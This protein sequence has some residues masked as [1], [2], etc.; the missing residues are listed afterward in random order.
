MR[1]MYK[2]T[3]TRFAILA[4]SAVNEGRAFGVETVQTIGLLV[5]EGVVLGH[6]LPSNLGRNDF[7]V[8][9]GGG[10]TVRHAGN[11]C[12][13]SRKPLRKSFLPVS[14]RSPRV[15]QYAPVWGNKWT[16]GVWSLEI[17][18]ILGRG[19]GGRVQKSK[20][21]TVVGVEGQKTR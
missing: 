14:F 9:C 3:V 8:N 16:C 2:L 4:F 20:Q 19:D 7:G 5:D 12:M 11:G 1:T 15:L 13:L 17:T 21:S 6:K 10:R 18:A